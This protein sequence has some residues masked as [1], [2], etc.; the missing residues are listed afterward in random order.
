MAVFIGLA[1]VPPGRCCGLHIHFCRVYRKHGNP[2]I[3]RIPRIPSKSSKRFPFRTR[4]I[5][6]I[7]S[8]DSQDSNGFPGFSFQPRIPE[9]QRFPSLYIQNARYCKGNS[10]DSKD[11]LRGFQGFSQRIPRIP[12]EDSVGFPQRIPRIP[13][14]PNRNRGIPKVPFS[15]KMDSLA[16]R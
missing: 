14:I 13:R 7:P 16:T 5:P 4:R 2:S 15:A 10:S 6:W 11:S 12:S 8:E 3:W 9:I 1:I